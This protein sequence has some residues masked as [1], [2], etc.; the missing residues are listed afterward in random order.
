MIRYDDRST[1]AVK[2]YLALVESTGWPGIVEKGARKIAEALS[3]SW[4][5]VC[6]YEGDRLVGSGRIVSDGAHQALICDLIVL[7]EYQGRGIG[8]EILTRLLKKCRDR[9][10]TM[11][12][13]FAAQGK[14]GYYTRFGFE[15]RPHDAPGMRW[16]KRDGIQGERLSGM[17]K[18]RR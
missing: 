6:A 13:L 4:Y 12:S 8:S 5:L 14:S 15:E 1:P 3:N 7:P 11:V 17:G 10:I 9:D 16:V 18:N 2:D